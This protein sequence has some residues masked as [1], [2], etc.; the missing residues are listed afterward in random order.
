MTNWKEHGQPFL[1]FTV[2]LTQ[3]WL[4][5]RFTKEQCKE[6]LSVGLKAEDAEYCCWLAKVIKLTPKEVLN[7]S[8]YEEK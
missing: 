7:E 6:W 4:I 3:Q 2:E 1:D 5:K 8:K